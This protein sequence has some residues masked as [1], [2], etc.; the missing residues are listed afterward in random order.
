MYIHD[1]RWCSFIKSGTPFSFMVSRSRN[2]FALSAL[3]SIGIYGIFLNKKYLY[4]SSGRELSGGYRSAVQ[5]FI[6][7]KL[8]LR[9]YRKGDW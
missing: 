8:T 6:R 2:L 1:P 4:N 7:N 9:L 5:I 3:I